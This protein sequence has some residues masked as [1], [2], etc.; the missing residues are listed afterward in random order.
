MNLVPFTTFARTLGAAGW[1]DGWPPHYAHDAIRIDKNLIASDTCTSCH[2]RTMEY[3]PMARFLVR[4]GHEQI[5]A[6]S[7]PGFWQYRAFGVC[8]HCDGW[9]EL[10]EAL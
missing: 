3:R 1:G 6:K 8:S 2:T 7:R 9:I 10:G 5:P 4:K